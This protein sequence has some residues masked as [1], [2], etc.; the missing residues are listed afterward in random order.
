LLIIYPLLSPVITFSQ[1][2]FSF[3]KNT[4]TSYNDLNA[5][6]YPGYHTTIS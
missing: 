5:R 3:D 4:L 2:P 6:A 1:T